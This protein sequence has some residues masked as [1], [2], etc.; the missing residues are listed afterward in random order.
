VELVQEKRED[1]RAW[2]SRL[3][4]L[5]CAG[6]D[7]RTDAEIVAGNPSKV[8]GLDRPGD[9]V[10]P[11]GK[12]LGAKATDRP[13]EIVGHNDIEAQHRNRTVPRHLIHG[14]EI[15]RGQQAGEGR[16]NAQDR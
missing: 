2:L 16:A 12:I 9:T 15:A 13:T 1:A 10:F 8:G 5:V 11:D 6:E 7:R 3:A 4:F 14:N